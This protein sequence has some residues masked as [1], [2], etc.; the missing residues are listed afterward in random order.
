MRYSNSLTRDPGPTIRQLT[1][2]LIF[3][4]EFISPPSHINMFTSST[5][6]SLIYIWHVSRVNEMHYQPAEILLKQSSCDLGT[7]YTAP[8]MEMNM[9]D[10][11]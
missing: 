7:G 6:L 4:S 8:N 2:P 3:P 1:A 9:Y 5:I 11:M 10:K